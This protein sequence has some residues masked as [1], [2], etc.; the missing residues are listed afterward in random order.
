MSPPRHRCSEAARMS[1]WWRPSRRP[2]RHNLTDS[3][4]SFP[5]HDHPALASMGLTPSSHVP[6]ARP[7]DR[8]GNARVIHESGL[9]HLRLGGTSSAIRRLRGLLK[10]I[11]SRRGLRPS[12]RRIG[13]IPRHRIHHSR[14]TCVFPD[15][16]AQRLVR[17]QE[18]SACRGGS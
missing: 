6:P 12:V 14:T 13:A 7:Q 5:I 3:A 17:F 9:T 8:T 1:C 15:N 16:F 2:C 18:E 11:P 10:S 4:A